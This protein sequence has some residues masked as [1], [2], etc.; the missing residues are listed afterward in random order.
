[1]ILT[2]NQL[3]TQHARKTGISAALLDRLL[4]NEP[5]LLSIAQHVRQLASLSDPIGQI[6]DG[7]LLANGLR[8]E[9]RRVPWRSSMKQG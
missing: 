3:D 4:L 8:F 6:I 7:G 2:A 1:M 5:R 9:R